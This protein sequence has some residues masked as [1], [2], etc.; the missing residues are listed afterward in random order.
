MRLTIFQRLTA[1]YLAIMLMVFI[2]GGYVAFQLNRLN[3]VTHLA[4][5][6]DSDVIQIAE[7]LSTKLQIL[8]SLEKKYW[9]SKDRDFYRLFLKRQKEFHDQLTTLTPLIFEARSKVFLQKALTLSQS[10]FRGVERLSGQTDAAPSADYDSE[11]DELISALSI[12]LNQIRQAANRTRDDKIRKS[13]SISATVLRMT[14]GLAAACIVVGLAV[15]LLTTKRIVHPIMVLQH[16]TRDVAAGHFVTIGDMKAPSEIRHLAEEFNTM[17]ERLKELDTLKEDFVSHVSH[18]L[19]TPL[20]A[21]WEAS[22]M[23]IKGTFDKDPQSRSQ[24]LTIVRDECKRLIVSVNR[25]LD[26]SRME[27]GM[28]DYQFTEIDLNEL[29]HSAV[30]KLSPIAQAKMI[31]LR[32]EGQSAIPPVLADNDQ[33]F[34]L[35]DNL[36]GNALKFTDAE[37]S[38]TVKTLTPTH[39]DGK[40]QVCVEDTGCGIEPEHLESIFSKFRRIEKGKNTVRGTGLGLAIAKHI[41]TAHGGSIWVESEKGSGSKFCFSLPPA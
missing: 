21:I 31:R 41:V 24:L 36:I 7:S 39:T 26:L 8:V 30:E 29:I 23:L 35:L 13:E 25:I 40:I 32:V 5:G 12:S 11:R 33:L 4:A 14:L 2:F 3:R 20:T 22:E 28:M 15:S 17:S 27:G 10:Y 16:K 6:A 1:G 19:R 37:G 34:Q 9:I 18:T 38:V